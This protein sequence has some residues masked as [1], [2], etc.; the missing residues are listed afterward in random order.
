MR[1]EV[2][3]LARVAVDQGEVVARVKIIVVTCSEGDDSVIDS[4]IDLDDG[5]AVATVT[6][7]QLEAVGVEDVAAFCAGLTTFGDLAP[8]T[9]DMDIEVPDV[10]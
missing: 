2:E 9:Y 10:E 3:D 8:G 4:A 5:T 6:A 1:L 7:A